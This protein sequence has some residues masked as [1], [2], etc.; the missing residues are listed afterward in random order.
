MNKDFIRGI[1]LSPD[2]A[3]CDLSSAFLMW[4]NKCLSSYD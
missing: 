3:K 2:I 1:Q 4:F